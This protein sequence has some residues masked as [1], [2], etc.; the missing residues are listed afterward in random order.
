[1]SNAG[2]WVNFR[3]IFDLR[4]ARYRLKVTKADEYESNPRI[5]HSKKLRSFSRLTK[6]ALNNVV[7]PMFSAVNSI[8]QHITPLCGLLEAQQYCSAIV[9]NIE[10]SGQPN[11][12]QCCFHQPRTGCSFFAVL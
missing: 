1:M 7:P 5:L 8:A 11:I 9:N 2:K 3:I 6:T 4:L 10:Q 12:F